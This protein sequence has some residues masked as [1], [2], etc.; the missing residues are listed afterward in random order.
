MANTQQGFEQRAARVA[1]DQ[2]K[3][4]DQVEAKE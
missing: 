2:R 3:I 1:D 4:Q